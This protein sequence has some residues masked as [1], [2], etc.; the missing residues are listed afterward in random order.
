MEMENLAL[1]EFVKENLKKR[2]YLTIIV[3]SRIFSIIYTK[4]KR[5]IENMY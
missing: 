4:E 3:I 1:R 5:K 2:I